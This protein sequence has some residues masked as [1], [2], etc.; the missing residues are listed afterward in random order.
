[1]KVG[2]LVK[3]APGTGRD[4]GVIVHELLRDR[5]RWRLFKVLWN[6]HLP[7]SPTMVGPAWEHN[8]EVISEAK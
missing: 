8:L 5:R 3:A 4:T 7:T 1:M 6:T 2:D